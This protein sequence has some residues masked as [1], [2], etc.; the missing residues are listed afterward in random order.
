MQVYQVPV[1]VDPDLT[2]L[3]DLL[4]GVEIAEIPDS[5]A[6]EDF[7]ADM[8][9]GPPAEDRDIRAPRLATH[10]GG[11]QTFAGTV[12]SAPLQVRAAW[13]YPAGGGLGWHTNSRKPGWRVY[14]VLPFG[15]S[16]LWTFDGT[17]RDWHPDRAGH[18]NLFRIDD[19]WRKS[20]HA[21]AADAPRLSL[22]LWAPDEWVEDLILRAGLN[23]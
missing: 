18:A 22:G 8:A 20:W 23:L 21:V 1:E 9:L 13:Y 19:D 4:K 5:V 3:H 16:G 15:E 2:R 7:S 17:T 12:V 14:V 11:L 6:F 10:L